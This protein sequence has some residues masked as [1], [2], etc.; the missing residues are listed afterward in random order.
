MLT[1][2]TGTFIAVD[3]FDAGVRSAIKTGG[4]I[5]P[6]FWGSFVLRVNF[7]GIGRFAI[8]CYSDIKNG[9]KIKIDKN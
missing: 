3:L 9:T 5:N 8:A 2:A 4:A 1:I 7:V 6:A